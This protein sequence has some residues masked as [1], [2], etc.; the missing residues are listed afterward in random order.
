MSEWI[1]IKLSLPSNNT[2]VKAKALVG[3]WEIEYE[4]FYSEENY[5][6]NK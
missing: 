6:K 4:W 2:W 5:E 1:D 3:K